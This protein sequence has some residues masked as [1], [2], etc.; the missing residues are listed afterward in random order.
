MH[1]FEVNPESSIKDV[2]I[3][4]GIS[5]RDVRAIILDLKSSG[6]FIG[7][8]STETGQIKYMASQEVQNSL[9]EKIKYCESCGTP[10][11]EESDQY[12]SYCGAKL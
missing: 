5:R 7:Q 4:T 8:F 3:A 1:E 9:E 11:S 6:Q 10:V 12:C 2:K